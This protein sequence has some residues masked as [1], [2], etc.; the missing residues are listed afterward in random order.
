MQEKHEWTYESE[1][2]LEPH[3]YIRLTNGKTTVYLSVSI[4]N[5]R[6]HYFASRSAEHYKATWVGEQK[7][8]AGWDNIED[9]KTAAL[10]YGYNTLNPEHVYWY[11]R[12]NWGVIY[13]E[14]WYEPIDATLSVFQMLDEDEEPIDD[15]WHWQFYMPPDFV[16][17][18]ADKQQG[19]HTDITA[20]Q[21]AVIEYAT[22][23][24][25][26][27]E[28]ENAIHAEKK[29]IEK[30]ALHSRKEANVDIKYVEGKPSLF[31]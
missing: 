1:N 7:E 16:T 8:K 18:S 21:K 20:A 13:Y 17:T 10:E 6:W 5:E 14:G 25:V 19:E 23:L 22:K 26:V 28:K 24:K 2:A 4:Y 27:I 12:H 29:R 3:H 9:A 15:Y 30:E 31:D 11:E